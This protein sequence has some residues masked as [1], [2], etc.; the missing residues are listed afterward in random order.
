MENLI[1]INKSEGGKQIVS[2]RELYQFLEIKRDFTNWC[3]DMFSYSFKESIDF[4][5]IMAKSTGGRPSKNYAITLDMAKHIS[6]IQ[7]SEKG[8]QARNYFIKVEKEYRNSMI[9]LPKTYQ[10]ALRELANT[11]D[12][13]EMAVLQLKEANDTIKENKSKVVFADS[14]AGSSNY[15][16]IRQFAKNLSDEGFKIGQNRLFKWFRDNKYLQANNEPY[17]KYVDQGLFKQIERVVGDPG[18]TI[19]TNTTK[20]SG[21]GQVYF[22]KKIRTP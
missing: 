17:Q 15:I 12:S 10:E 16:L 7:R 21:K 22:A 20:L 11:K 3:K 19:T 4:T 13:E 5:P 8:M 2:A 14:V 9:A 18:N 6:M 1:A